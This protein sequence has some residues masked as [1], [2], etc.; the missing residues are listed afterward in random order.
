MDSSYIMDRHE[1]AK[2]L[3][4]IEI[5]DEFDRAQRGIPGDHAA[6]LLLGDELHRAC[7]DKLLHVKERYVIERAGDVH[8]FDDFLAAQDKLGTIPT[9]V[10]TS[11]PAEFCRRVYENHHELACFLQRTVWREQYVGEKSTGLAIACR[12]L[13]LPPEACVYVGDAPADQHA[14]RQ[15][16]CHFVAYHRGEHSDAV[17]LAHARAVSDHRDLAAAIPAE[18]RAIVF[19]L[20]GTIINTENLHVAGWTR[21]LEQLKA[22]Y[23]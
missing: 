22:E 18:T 10:C 21:A 2:R 9:W 23:R 3:D 13:D 19:D 14:A 4:E 7:G 16:G 17:A 11:A 6:R 8:I 15:T 1:I 20:D 12:R 5:S